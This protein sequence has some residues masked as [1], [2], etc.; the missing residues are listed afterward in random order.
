MTT[1]SHLLSGTV[2]ARVSLTISSSTAKSSVD[3]KGFKTNTLSGASLHHGKPYSLA[4]KVLVADIINPGTN[5]STAKAKELA[6]SKHLTH[7]AF[8]VFNLI[9]AKPSST[10]TALKSS[11][12]Y[13]NEK[14]LSN[15][16][17]VAVG[18][19][20]NTL[21]SFTVQ[22]EVAAQLAPN[23]KGNEPD[24]ND[25]NPGKL[26]KIASTFA[27][28]PVPA[29]DLAYEDNIMSDG[30]VI[31]LINSEM[32][33]IMSPISSR[34]KS[35]TS[36]KSHV[37][38]VQTKIVPTSEIVSERLHDPNMNKLVKKVA[39]TEHTAA[40]VKAFV[41]N[42][43]A[44][45]CFKTATAR[46]A[47]YLN[48]DGSKSSMF[49]YSMKFP[50]TGKKSL[51]T[52]Q[53]DFLPSFSVLC[54]PLLTMIS[55][56]ILSSVT[57]VNAIQS[58]N[59]NH[60]ALE[61]QSELSNSV[62]FMFDKSREKDE[63]NTDL[64]SVNLVGS[65]ED[66]HVATSGD[67]D[68]PLF[69][70]LDGND[71]E[72]VKVKM[73]HMNIQTQDATPRLISFSHR[74]RGREDK[75]GLIDDA[76]NVVQAQLE[77]VQSMHK[78]YQDGDSKGLVNAVRSVIGG[79]TA[80]IEDGK[81]STES[82]QLVLPVT[83]SDLDAIR[84]LQDIPNSQIADFF[85]PQL[86]ED[87]VVQ[88]QDVVSVLED[89]KSILSPFGV[90][91]RHLQ[92]NLFSPGEKDGCAP[93]KSHQDVV[94][95]QTNSKNDN[96]P[97]DA[98]NSPPQ[99]F[100]VNQGMLESL[101]QAR[102]VGLAN[103]PDISKYIHRG[104]DPDSV[105]RRL[106]VNER[107]K[108]RLQALDVCHPKCDP[109]DTPCNCNRLV[110]CINDM[111]D[112][113]VALLFVGN[114]I[115]KESGNLTAALNL[116][117]AD[118][119][120]LNRIQLIRSLALAKIAVS[121]FLSCTLHVI[122]Q[123]KYE[124]DGYW[125]QLS[126]SAAC[127]GRLAF[128]ACEDFA[129]EFDNLYRGRDNATYPDWNP[130]REDPAISVDSSHIIQFPTQYKFQRTVQGVDEFATMHVKLRVVYNMK[131]CLHA[132]NDASKNV[133]MANCT[134]G[135]PNQDFYYVPTTRQIKLRS[136]GDCV[137]I[138]LSSNNA[139]M[140]SCHGGNNQKW[141][142]N[143]ITKELKT[144]NDGKCLDMDPVSGNVY[145][146]GSCHGGNNQKFVLPSHWLHAMTLY[147]VRVFSEPDKCMD[148]DSSRKIILSTCNE[149][150]SSQ[151]FKYDS[152]T[153]QIKPSLSGYCFDYNF[154]NQDVYLYTCH[155]GLNQKWYFE[156]STNRIRT[157]YDNKCLNWTA[158][159]F[160]MAKCDGGS[161]K[162]FQIPTPW[163][164]EISTS[165]F[166][167][168]RVFSNLKL[169]FELS[170]GTSTA[171]SFK[172]CNGLDDSNQKIYYDAETLQIK[173]WHT[174]FCA[175]LDYGNP[176]LNVYMYP[177]HGGNNQKWY[178]E[179]STNR[180]RTLHNQFCMEVASDSKVYGRNCNFE[181]NQ[182]FLVPSLWF[183]RRSNVIRLSS[184]F[185]KC[186]V[187][188][189]DQSNNV[190]MADCKEGQGLGQNFEYDSSTNE[191]KQDGLCLDI[192]FPDDSRLG[193]VKTFG[194][195]NALMWT[196][197]GNNSQKWSLDI[198]RNQI[199]TLVAFTS[200][201]GISCL[202]LEANGNIIVG[203]C[204]SDSMPPD[205]AFLFPESWTLPQ[206]TV[207][208]TYNP[209]ISHSITPAIW[210]SN[211]C[212]VDWLKDAVKTCDASMELLLGSSTSLGT[213]R[214]I[215]QDVNNHGPERM[216]GTC[217]LDSPVTSQFFGYHYDHSTMK[218]QNPGPWHLGI[219]VEACKNAQ[220]RWFRSPCVTLKE[221]IDQH[222]K[223]GTDQFSQSFENFAR[224]LVI[225]DPRN[226]ARCKE[227][228]EE[229]GFD[230]NHPFDTEVCQ[231]F[232]SHLCEGFFT[233]VDEMVE[234]L[235][236]VPE[237]Q[238][239]EYKSIK[240][241]D[242][243]KLTFDPLPER[244]GQYPAFQV[245]EYGK[246][247]SLSSMQDA[248]IG[249]RHTVMVSNE[250]WEFVNGIDKCASVENIPLPFGGM[251]PVKTICLIIQT[252]V[253]VAV[254]G[255][256]TSL[257]LAFDIL[258]SVYEKTMD[259]PSTGADESLRIQT[260]FDNLKSFDMWTTTSLE[261][262]NKNMVTQHTEMR[263]QLQD[264]HLSMEN[265]INKF[266]ESVQ[267]Y[268][269][270][271]T[272]NA[273]QAL[274]NGHEMLKD[275]LES[276]VMKVVNDTYSLVKIIA[277]SPGF[278]GINN[279]RD[280]IENELNN[281]YSASD[282]SMSD[283]QAPK[284]SCG[285]DLNSISSGM[286]MNVPV[287]DNTTLFVKEDMSQAAGAIPLVLLTEEDNGATDLTVK[288]TVRSNSAIAGR[289]TVSLF[290]KSSSGQLEPYVLPLT[291]SKLNTD[292][293][294]QSGDDFILY[295]FSFV[296]IS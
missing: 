30:S 6:A 79:R 133:Y 71:F 90:S 75:T 226:E 127:G 27:L 86:F 283:R 66:M 63:L 270:K 73:N 169:C 54:K 16:G 275:I 292:I 187:Y 36:V 224:N 118:F 120:I 17:L 128:S 116:F 61:D 288:V 179:R 286:T 156:A 57:T 119:N 184:N 146:Y 56:L 92:A 232:E 113:D 43:D 170:S 204:K 138:H 164:D 31:D 158:T 166:D 5:K 114:Y 103:L 26:A 212:V 253:K 101:R 181:D 273:S 285:F 211:V 176:N 87:M 220:G 221:C 64:I 4:I 44:K 106:K 35:T 295:E 287:E 243:P 148:V 37:S 42:P 258:S 238:G 22:A 112:Y 150:Q 3:S 50:S 129:T 250:A 185:Y 80:F 262:I 10:T 203:T 246:M 7:A 96:N 167:E 279:G 293:C 82:S 134:A 149:T 142:Y 280:L 290:Y 89:V 266:T 256:R 259:D 20:H 1:S 105:N 59:S 143:P 49:G 12:V 78:M 131:K 24:L 33:T 145:M 18:S 206:Q 196:C 225:D 38:T 104:N 117:D 202:T 135:S 28:S 249:L 209:Y 72:G 21:T 265:N 121:S 254:Y 236:S 296:A 168:M 25:P 178:Y 97:F 137:D 199:K 126:T 222:P 88:M 201:G 140:H 32:A 192:I 70:V 263:T 99:D 132:A 214:A 11:V 58:E 194:V 13:S 174:G 172:T 115:D 62:N 228:R 171:L 107:H 268:L 244:T 173:F 34:S 9:A 65:N 163:L 274:A 237:F 289:T 15:N 123:K 200:L 189:P 2:P 207:P 161:S 29:E 85:E 130:M 159:K 98:K 271:Y 234:D 144:Y 102:G 231:K 41:C 91:Q 191:I 233:E 125:G 177:C 291:C 60:F 175:D 241:P 51:K 269:G 76:Q 69:N 45:T 294:N 100:T 68:K 180:I 48:K 83:D 272:N 235:S 252:A 39:V 261:T 210:S 8:D 239:V 248:V 109:N 218:C 93:N 219:T 247:T 193:V 157:G 23:S 260:M 77:N 267:T 141:R 216:P 281:A 122:L 277:S 53:K 205:Q 151:I 227:V 152:A 124:L 198:E 255:T 215:A 197:N 55:L 139:Y 190:Y 182:K 251:I 154:N 245:P 84:D 19:N 195:Q 95:Y 46:E 110:G 14:F 52:Y 213:L 240:Y 208:V 229:L 186:M 147:Q 94:E 47:L 40:A 67:L 223:N 162:K 183:N 230:S 276:D 257:V 165:S 155:G 111:T 282:E 160:V 278:N 81:L 153:R 217:C 188:D 108:R 74:L 136:T 242:D 264:R 284:I